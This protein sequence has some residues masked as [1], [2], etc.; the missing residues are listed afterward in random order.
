LVRLFAIT[1]MVASSASFIALSSIITCQR[2]GLA[3]T[4]KE[5]RRTFAWAPG[6]FPHQLTLT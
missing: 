6:I 4:T 5:V 3:V 1:L 2:F